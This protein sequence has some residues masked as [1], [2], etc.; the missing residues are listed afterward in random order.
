MFPD[1]AARMTLRKQIYLGF[2]VSVILIGLMAVLFFSLSYRIHYAFEKVM[3]SNLSEQ[4]ITDQMRAQTERIFL[5]TRDKEEGDLTEKQVVDAFLKDLRNNLESL[6]KATEA[7]ESLAEAHDDDEEV[8]GEGE[9]LEAIEN[10]SEALDEIEEKWARREVVSYSL[11]EFCSDVDE[12]VLGIIADLSDDAREEFDQ[13]YREIADLRESTAFM[14]KWVTVIVSIGLVFLSARLALRLNKPIKALSKAAKAIGEG[15]FNF[16]I[17]YESSD[18]LGRLAES[19]NTMSIQIKDTTVSRDIMDMI[20]DSMGSG[21]FVLDRKHRITRMNRKILDLLDFEESDLMS[22]SFHQITREVHEKIIEHDANVEGCLIEE[23]EIDSKSG[24]AIPFSVILTRI[25]QCIETTDSVVVLQ[26]MRPFR[27]SQN[28]LREAKRTA[29]MA[30]EL[31]TEFLAN[32]SHEIRTPMN[33]VVAMSDLLMDTRLDETQRSFVKTIISASN[34]M[35]T[36]INEILDFSKIEAGKMSLSTESVE[37]MPFLEETIS[38]FSTNAHKKRLELILDI[39]DEVPSILAVD[40]VRLRQ[41][42]INTLGNAIKFTDSGEVRLRVHA[43]ASRG[44]RSSISFEVIDTGRGIAKKDYDLV[45]EMFRQVDGGLTRKQEGTGLGLSICVKILEL[46]VSKLNLESEL[47][48]GS[49]FSFILDLEVDGPTVGSE[50]EGE[51]NRKCV[52]LSQ[53][54]SVNK[55]IERNLRHCGYSCEILKTLED[56]QTIADLSRGFDIVWIDGS[57]LRAFESPLR[58]LRSILAE[59]KTVIVAVKPEETGVYNEIMPDHDRLLQ[60][61]KPLLLSE[62]KRAL[63]AGHAEEEDKKTSDSSDGGDVD[64]GVLDVLVVDDNKINLKVASRILGKWG[65]NVTVADSGKSALQRISEHEYD[66]VLMDIQMPDMDGFETTRK[67]REYLSDKRMK[68]PVAIAC[69]AHAVKG[70]R[71][72]CLEKHLDGYVT[73]PIKMESIAKE[74]ERIFEGHVDRSELN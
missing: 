58:I 28:A 6:R 38:M 18:E 34:N 70:Y 14:I 21:V 36:L 49:C 30:N 5:L 10:L 50:V 66:V 26:D 55:V 35:M 13:E 61:H 22:R 33:G 42:L 2:G 9:E 74:L 69:T 64:L 27:D 11:A 72:F 19:F 20:I 23:V 71:E 32:I 15:N 17:E 44:G 16:N 46:M 45:F 48:K 63:L 56:P 60:I 52:V 59:N 7:G 57:V 25:Q 47:N 40:P 3:S 65:H 8:E 67:V 1:G 73:K 37:T 29:E 39:D 51:A 43:V 41:V 62:M 68:Q 4:R 12:G 54:D 24:E 53:L 31:K